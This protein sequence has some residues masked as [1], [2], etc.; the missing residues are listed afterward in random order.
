MDVV[1]EGL[2]VERDGRRVLDASALHF[3]S[4][5]TTAL[6]G[7]NGAGKTT[8]LRCVAGLERPVAGRVTVGGGTPA[9]ARLAYAFQRPVFVRGTVGRNL[10]LGLELR[11]VPP[12]ER[13]ERVRE[14]AAE[15]GVEPL[16]DRPAHKLSGGEAQR[17]NLARALALRA[18]VT[19]LDEP[20]AGL[21]RAT[22]VQLLDDLPRLLAAF[23]TTALVVTH[24]REEAF[25]LAEHLVVLSAGAVIASGPKGQL[26]RAPPNRE[27]AELLG[28]TVLDL[29]GS[30]LA[31]PAGGLRVV[32]G[33]VNPPRAGARSVL[34][35]MRV[36][37]IVDMGNHA[38]VTGTAAGTRLD[39]R[40]P[41]G[42]APPSPGTQV[43]VVADGI[44]VLR[45]SAL[46]SGV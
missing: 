16:I 37:R 43:T 4:G 25:R 18:P 17:V 35:T 31:V 13:A 21:D 24:D 19:L 6:F 12:R 15:C 46:Q 1:V 27:S 5:T 7:P 36:E 20:L 29:D 23:A 2:R 26:Y 32:T 33:P 30:L 42:L 38:H 44:V 11:G 28:H 41:D 8:L 22:R 3:A 14:V 34:L 40:V 39:A 9:V 10:A 45:L